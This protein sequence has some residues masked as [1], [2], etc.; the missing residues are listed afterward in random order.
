M[1]NHARD[2]VQNELVS[3]LYKDDH[4]GNL[5]K[6]TDDIAQRRKTCREMRELLQR[7]LEIVNEV[8]DFNNFK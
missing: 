5:M 7:A 1:V 8:R 6:E 2:S 4:I 3:E